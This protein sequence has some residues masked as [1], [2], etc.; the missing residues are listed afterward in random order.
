MSKSKKAHGR[1]E[2]PIEMHV[3]GIEGTRDM[4]REREN[5]H[6]DGKRVIG[7][8]CRRKKER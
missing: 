3:A 2:R 1:D 6:K 7:V 8:R 4:Y 5:V